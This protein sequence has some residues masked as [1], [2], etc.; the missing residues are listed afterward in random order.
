MKAM[1]TNIYRTFWLL[2][3]LVIFI[4][5][6]SACLLDVF[7]VLEIENG[8]DCLVAISAIFGYTLSAAMIYVPFDENK[9]K[10]RAKLTTWLSIILI[11]FLL[12]AYVVT[13]T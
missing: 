9:E 4:S 1:L 8:L 3:C 11:N 10:R 5:S 12:H 7:G 2:P 13:F 6:I